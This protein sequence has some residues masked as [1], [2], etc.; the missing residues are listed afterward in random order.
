[1]DNQLRYILFYYIRKMVGYNP[2][3]ML[4]QNRACIIQVILSRSIIII[5]YKYICSFVHL[6]DSKKHTP[7]FTCSIILYCSELFFQQT[8]YN[9]PYIPSLVHYIYLQEDTLS[10]KQSHLNL[11]GH[12]MNTS[13]KTF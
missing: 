7:T 12:Y 10:P 13:P 3:I 1:M 9:F 4:Q 8:S 2:G 5:S 6:C 11:V